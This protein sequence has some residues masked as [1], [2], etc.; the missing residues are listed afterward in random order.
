M[1]ISTI[2]AFGGIAALCIG[3]PSPFHRFFGT[4]AIMAAFPFVVY[5]VREAGEHILALVGTPRPNIPTREAMNEAI[6][7]GAGVAVGFAM[8]WRTS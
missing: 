6:H 8:F 7:S 1:I 4:L 3:R 5:F 2:L